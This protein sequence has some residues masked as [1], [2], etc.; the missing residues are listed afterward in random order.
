[1]Q[2]W[3]LKNIVIV[4]GMN[5]WKSYFWTIVSHLFSIIILKQIF[6]LVLVASDGY[7]YLSSF[8]GG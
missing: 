2:E 8:W 7:F 5:D 6:T 1:M 4:I 3:H